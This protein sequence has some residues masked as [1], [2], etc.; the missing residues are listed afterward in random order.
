[1]LR[2]GISGTVRIRFKGVGGEHEVFAPYAVLAGYVQARLVRCEH[3]GPQYCWDM[4]EPYALRPFVHV[5]EVPYA[6][7]GSV[8]VA[9]ALFPQELSGECVKLVATGAF[10]EYCRAPGLYV[11]SLPV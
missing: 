3:S 10:G 7:P 5:E 1:M 9:F 11:L 8:Q 2:F 4:V 6:V